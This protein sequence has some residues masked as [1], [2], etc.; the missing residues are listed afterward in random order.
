LTGK[1]LTKKE[2]I[3]K[4]EKVCC[5]KNWVYGDSIAYQQGFQHAA[6]DFLADLANLE[7]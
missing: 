6:R 3:E 1:K 5:E 4:W 7:D 2:L